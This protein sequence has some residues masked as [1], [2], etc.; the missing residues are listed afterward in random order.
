MGE[1]I[2]FTKEEC[3]AMFSGIK[4]DDHI[5]QVHSS[6]AV[7]GAAGGAATGGDGVAATGGDG[8]DGVAAAGGCNYSTACHTLSNFCMLN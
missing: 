4:L 1:G 3:E 7:G 5:M 8:G 6:A 2:G